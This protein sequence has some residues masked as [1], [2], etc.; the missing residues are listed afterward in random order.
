M[1]YKFFCKSP[2]FWKIEL[3]LMVYIKTALNRYV[4]IKAYEHTKVRY[5]KVRYLK[6]F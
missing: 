4:F 2:F 3:E 5:L 1:K 6:H